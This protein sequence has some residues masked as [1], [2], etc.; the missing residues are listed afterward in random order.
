MSLKQSITE[1]VKQAMRA[2]DKTTLSTL[3]LV[4]AEIKQIEVDQRI[5]LTD[6]DVVGVLD[7][8]TKKRRDAIAQF[9]QANRAD[10]VEQEQKELKV[11][12]HFLPQPLTQAEL[13]VLIAEAIAEAHAEQQ[14]DVGKVMH[15]L[16]PKIT[17]RADMK[18]LSAQVRQLLL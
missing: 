15:L 17:G 1:A 14:K 10:L 13:D 11:I 18:Q 2:Q 3:R 16:R 12:Q 6:A 8:M 5:E 9:R 4:Q 7:K